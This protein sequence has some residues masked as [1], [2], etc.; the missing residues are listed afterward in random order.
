M[1]EILFVFFTFLTGYA[2]ITG[3]VKECGCFGDCIK[4]TA[5]ESFAKDIILFILIAFLLAKRNSVE[6]ILKSSQSIV[7][8]SITVLFSF[9][10]QELL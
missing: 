5:G 9:L 2:V 1:N 4:L 8:L 6:S 3:S 7:L 10:I